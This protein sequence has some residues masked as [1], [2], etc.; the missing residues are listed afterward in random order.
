MK[1][2]RNYPLLLASQFLGALGDNVILAII[3]GPVMKSFAEGKITSQEQSIANI[4]YTSLLFVPYLLCASLA[5]YV[6]DRF[7]KTRWL[8]LGN[9]VKLAGSAL[10]ALHASTG[11][12]ALAGGYLVVGVGACFYSPAKYGILPEILPTERLVKANG[13]VELLTLVAIL[14]GNIVGSMIADGVNKGALTSLAAYGSVCGIYALS[15]GLNLFMAPTPSYPEVQFRGST[16]HFFSNFAHL[17]TSA[18]LRRVLVGTGLFWICG[19][20]M[21]MNFQP[22][23]QQVLKLETM[24]QVALLGLWLSLGVM[25][26]SV[27]AGHLHKVGDLRTTRRYG[28]FLAVAIALLGAVKWLTGAGLPWPKPFA[29]GVLIVAG[30]FAGLFLIPLNAALQAE[31]HQDK[32]GKTIATQNF[33]ENTAMLGA[34]LFAW[35]NVKQGF[36]PSQL[37]YCLA[38]LVAVVVAWLKIPELVRTGEKP[39]MN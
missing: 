27:L 35:V 11:E 37:F 36:D 2:T 17:F 26:G 18:R 5:G 30:L 38:V 14:A 24:T 19:A 29:I 7:P 22:W 4:F 25:A 1:S 28:A 34:S 13:T 3:L 9:A 33:I 23:G 32:L 6:N 8:A 21:K 20:L 15:L 39:A 10:A 31:S 16:G 12:W